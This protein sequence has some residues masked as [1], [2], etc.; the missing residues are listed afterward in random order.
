MIK[1]KIKSTWKKMYFNLFLFPL[2]ILLVSLSNPN[3]TYLF[4]VN[5]LG[6]IF[7]LS[8]HF[9]KKLHIRENILHYQYW[10][11]IDSIDIKNIKSVDKY[12]VLIGMNPVC[13]IDNQGNSRMKGIRDFVYTMEDLDLFLLELRKINPN[14]TT[15]ITQMIS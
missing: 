15:N 1:F 14:I 4:L 10:W 11:Y 9:G 6:T 8:D 2:I 7:I 12:W 5:I 3:L 13:I